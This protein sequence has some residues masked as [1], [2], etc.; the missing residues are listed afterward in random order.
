MTVVPE[1]IELDPSM[2]EHPKIRRLSA[3]AFRL[4]MRAVFYAFR[5]RT[6]GFVDEAMLRELA[7]VRRWRHLVDE[8]RDAALIH[9][10]AGGWEIH[11]YL[12]WQPSRED[13]AQSRA[14]RRS[15]RRAD[16]ERKKRV[17]NVRADTPPTP[18]PQEG[19]QAG[20]CLPD[21]SGKDLGV[22]V[23]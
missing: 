13:V 2:V 6:N 12:D 15:R 21:L 16:R 11:D 8:L 14:G 18:P 10:V 9:E 23:S 22:G 19:R 20:P 4:H 1:P 17:R 5:C 3:A 7:T